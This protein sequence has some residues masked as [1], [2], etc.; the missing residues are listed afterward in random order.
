MKD[1]HANNPDRELVTQCVEIAGH[2]GADNGA[3]K[4]DPDEDNQFAEKVTDR[5]W[6]AARRLVAQVSEQKAKTPA[7]GVLAQARLI[8]MLLDQDIG[9]SVDE[10]TIAFIRSFAVSVESFIESQKTA[11]QKA[12]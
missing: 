6:R 12:P 5:H 8:P 1:N 2:F 9:S 7:I 10:N 11:S 3:F 4:V